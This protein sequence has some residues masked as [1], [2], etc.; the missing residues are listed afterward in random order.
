MSAQGGTLT[1]RPLAGQDYIE[2]E[3]AY[4]NHLQGVTTNGA[5]AIYWSFTD[6][7]VKTDTAG[8]AIKTIDVLNHHGDLTYANGRIYVAVNDMVSSPPGEFNAFNANNP[9]RQWIYA[10]DANTLAEVAKYPVPQ[11]LYGAG[12]IAYHDD[13]FLVVGGLPPGH[14]A[15]YVHQY[16]AAFEYLGPRNLPTGY[17]FR[18]I[19]TAEFAHGSWWFGTYHDLNG[20]TATRQLFRYNE[21]LSSF[22]QS[23]LDASLGL[24]LLPDG[25]FLVGKNRRNASNLY[26]GRVELAA[27]NASGNLTIIPIPVPE[28]HT[29]ALVG[30]A[31]VI[32]LRAR[33]QSR[34]RRILCRP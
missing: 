31:A 2:C 21:P 12:G 18:G 6:K 17:T 30:G 13:K 33:Q 5:N 1:L 4:V 27:L 20:N 25:T 8:R 26:V 14:T 29:A 10:Y 28:P 23:S 15:N 24:A 32:S 34:Q 11:L 7:L 19:Q 3:G 22:R 9:P 16:N